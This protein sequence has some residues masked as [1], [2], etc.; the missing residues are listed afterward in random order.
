MAQESLCGLATLTTE[1][2]LPFR[3]RIDKL[4]YRFVTYNVHK[5]LVNPFGIWV[6]G[7]SN[8]RLVDSLHRIS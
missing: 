6:F 5:A 4:A 3:H 1:T 7:C 8:Y 2:R